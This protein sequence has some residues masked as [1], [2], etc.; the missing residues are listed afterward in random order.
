MAGLVPATHVLLDGQAAKEVV[1]ARQRMTEQNPE[2]TPPHFTALHA[3][4]EATRPSRAILR[5]T[6]AQPIDLF[7]LFGHALQLLAQHP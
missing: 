7:G 2:A 5:L 6:V 1:D 3:R 4:Y